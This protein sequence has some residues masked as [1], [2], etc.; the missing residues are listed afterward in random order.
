MNIRPFLLL[1]LAG[2]TLQDVGR[3]PDSTA[4]A[5]ARLGGWRPDA[6]TAPS[7]DSLAND[8]AGQSIRRGHALFAHTPDSL[9]GYV[10]SNLTCSACHIE[11]GRRPTAVPLFGVYGMYPKYIARTGA[12]VSIEDR[13]NY[14]FT[15]SLAGWKL[16]SESREMA[17]LVAYLAFLSRGV[18]VG[19][20]AMPIALKTMPKMHGDSTVGAGLFT[21]T[22][23]RCHGPDGAGLLAVPALWGPKSFSVGAS[24]ARTE[25]AASF[26]R[27]NM[28]FDKPG[29]L[30]DQEAF[31]VAAYMTSLPRPDLPGKEL[32]WPLGGAPA[33]VPYATQGRSPTQKTPKLFPRERPADAIVGAP[34]RVPIPTSKRH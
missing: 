6:W 2:C 13:V 29:T 11:E 14:C 32:D 18:P 28:P 9:P 8:A 5:L 27:Q 19:A 33:D 30:T 7:L 12:I 4:A 31:D 34:K 21:A 24:M 3:R 15:R 17:D 16:P 10:G 26:I 25:R 20:E 22:C 23:A 1:S